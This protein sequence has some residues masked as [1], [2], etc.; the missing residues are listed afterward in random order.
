MSCLP[1][2]PPQ[3]GPAAARDAST[4]EPARLSDAGMSASRLRRALDACE[5]GI[6]MLD[7]DLR[8]VFVNQRTAGVLGYSPAEM[9]GRHLFDFLPPDAHATAV[10]RL[11]ARRGG[12]QMPATAPLVRKDGSRFVAS[13]TADNVLDDEGRYAGVIAIVSERSREH[14]IAD[15]LRE[16]EARYR[17][18]YYNT[19]AP[20]MLIDPDTAA[21]VD[22]NPAACEFYGYPHAE[23]TALR[24]TDLN[25]TPAEEVEER[26]ASA[27]AG[28]RTRFELRHRLK[29]GDV[30][31]V[32]VFS[33]A[34][35]MLGRQLLFSI[36]HDITG[37]KRAEAALRDSE[38][39]YRL[40]F[41]SNP[42]PMWVYD[43]ETLAFRVVNDSAV[44]A[45]GY[46]REE[47]LGMTMAAIHPPDAVPAM[48]ASVRDVLGELRRV[49][50]WRH[51]RK[52][53]TT[54]DA[55]ITT[56]D[57]LWAGRPS[58]LVLAVDVSEHQRTEEALR[59]SGETLNALF[60]AAPL[61]VV[62]IGPD[63]RVQMW[64]PAAERIFGWS[65]EEVLGEPYPLVPVGHAEE[66]ERA[67]G[68]LQR[69]QGVTSM[70]TQ[71][72]R[73]DGSLVE[74]SISAAPV[75]GAGGGGVSAVAIL[76][77]M[78]ERR[79]LARQLLHA[80]KMEG[81]GRLAG[82]VAHDFNN[83]LTAI[84]GYSEMAAA[85]LPAGSEARVFLQNVESAAMR[86]SDLT[87]QLLAFAR[88]Q[89][90][91]PRIVDLNQIV[92]NMDRLLR[93]LIGEDIE[94]VTLLA[95]GIW[96][97]RADPGQVEQVLVNLVVNARDAMPDGGKLTVETQC[98]TLDE[99]WVRRGAGVAGGDYVLLAVSDTGVGMNEEVRAHIY[100]P[101][102][103]TKEVG[104]GTGLGLAT[105]FGIVQQNGGHIAAYSEPGYGTT[106]KVYLP[107]AEGVAVD[108]GR[109]ASADPPAGGR[110]TILLAED[111]PLV[112]EM[113]EHI[114]RSQGYRVLAA[115]SGAD[116][117]AVASRHPGDIHL[118]VADV[119]MPGMG[120]QAIAERLQASRP[121][122]R[123][124]Y[125]SGYTESSVVRMGAL[126]EGIAFLAKP[127]TPGALA[128]KVREV[129]D[130]PGPRPG[131]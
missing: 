111:E 128:R 70:Q 36:V 96:P 31:D 81:I 18:M 86:A 40:V 7:A 43:R 11:A 101:F 71:R 57:L 17:A 9:E 51:R 98:V 76:E 126:E 61:A 47:F 68:Q 117:V 130:T 22:A 63:R 58:R 79:E 64:N 26:M 20:M 5:R 55:E 54:L 4:V 2:D 106:M 108:L 3:V 19:H 45:Y 99:A 84:L 110:E 28:A 25:V 112:R 129:L 121:G 124:L 83:L 87:R 39:R 10:E 100:E 95:P 16:S 49:G 6:W 35:V 115:R 65:A 8:T 122:L 80:Q 107:R 127:F 44:R 53:G 103:T 92:V 21:I 131:A 73:R 52:D 15:A 59:E 67:W 97:V 13:I 119:V 48:V 114:L 89:P 42:I 24:L 113:A 66:H 125:V 91:E 29:G 23:I 12:E 118:L 105:C 75:R 27:R 85:A 109:A 123:A 94:V 60:A 50:V 37:R 88:R 1:N 90:A 32:E 62:L 120:G 38:A 102:F 74:V 72:Q 82:G 30:R 116:A 33:G 104:K 93:R 56:H 14:E 41:E 77:D 46:S 78:T 34:T 69:G